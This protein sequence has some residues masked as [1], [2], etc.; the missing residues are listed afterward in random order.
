MLK[1]HDIRVVGLTTINGRCA[2]ELGGPKFNL[3]RRA[4]EAATPACEVWVDPNTYVPI[5]EVVD[6]PPLFEETQTWIEYKT[7]PITPANERLLSLIARHPYARI[8]RNHN[9]Y[10]NAAN[11]DVVFTG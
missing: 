5:K 8:D 7:L 4:T 6:R 11:G 9:D 2:I 3:R 10:L 1:S